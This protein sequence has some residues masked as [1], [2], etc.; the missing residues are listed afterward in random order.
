MLA[1]HFYTKQYVNQHCG[2]LYISIEKTR[3]KAEN[4]LR[5]SCL[6]GVCLQTLCTNVCLG[7]VCL[8]SLFTNNSVSRFADS[9]NRF[10]DKS[11]LFAAVF[12]NRICKSGSV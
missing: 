10:I 2:Q 12:T 7:G 3:A 9:F 8:E 6:K 5:P 4:I 1:A 11:C